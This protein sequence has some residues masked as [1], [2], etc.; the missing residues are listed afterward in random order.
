MKGQK[1]KNKKEILELKDQLARAL[2]DY[3]NLRKRVEREEERVRA[4]AVGHVVGA[5]LPAF[6][7]FFEAQKHLGDSGL[8]MGLKELTESL[9]RLGVVE[10]NPGSGEAFNEAVHE[11]VDSVEAKEIKPGRVAETALR[12]WKFAEGPVI[13]YAKVV[14]VKK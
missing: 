12:G 9:K 1:R 8:A 11:A 3:D 10:V 13:R 4:S 14:V 6:D 2:A 7:M 5:L